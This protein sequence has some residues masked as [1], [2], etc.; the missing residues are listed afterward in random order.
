MSDEEEA[1]VI[2]VQ[3]KTRKKTDMTDAALF[4]PTSPFDPTKSAGDWMMQERRERTSGSRLKMGIGK[5]CTGS[6][7]HLRTMLPTGSSQ[8]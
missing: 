6:M 1:E 2:A 3:E 8:P 5:D 7:S 4:F